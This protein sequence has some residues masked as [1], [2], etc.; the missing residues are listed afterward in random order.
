MDGAAENESL[1]AGALIY[2][3]SLPHSNGYIE[4]KLFLVGNSFLVVTEGIFVEF[5]EK[6][7]GIAFFFPLALLEFRKWRELFN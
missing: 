7:V 5:F 2:K 4:K 6:E 3:S 1:S